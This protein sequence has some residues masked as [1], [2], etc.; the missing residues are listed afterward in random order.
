M[1]ALLIL[2]LLG[3][4]CSSPDRSSPE[5]EKEKVREVIQ[6]YARAWEAFDSA[7][8]LALFTEDAVISPSGLLPREGKQAMRAF[9]FPPDGP[10][11]TVESYD[12]DVLD[13]GVSD[14]L[15]YTFEKGTLSY[16]FTAGDMSV[17]RTSR[18]YGTT[19]YRKTGPGEWKIFRRMWTDLR[20]EE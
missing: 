1:R 5:S 6:A 16:A 3:V 15:A 14:S 4:G 17:E 20:I 8:V 7:A 10:R 19:L 2:L 18:A 12:I 9:W 13:T 11:V